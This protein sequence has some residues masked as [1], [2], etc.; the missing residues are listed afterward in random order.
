MPTSASRLPQTCRS[1]SVIRA[2]PGSAVQTRTPTDCCV[3]TSREEPT[4]RVSP[5][6]TSTASPCGS[7]NVRE[8]PWASKRQPINYE[9]RCTDRLNSQPQPDIKRD[10]SAFCAR[11]VTTKGNEWRARVPRSDLRLQL[12]LQLIEEAPVGALGDELLG[13]ALDHPDL[14][15]AQGVEAQGVLGA[16]LAPTGRGSPS[17]P[18]GH[19]RSACV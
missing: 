11:K 10:W 3:S 15:Q 7:I 2:V 9:R 13:A 18:G 14:V 17:W 19:S 16:I 8:R 1:T 5:R 12:P 6:A 4:S